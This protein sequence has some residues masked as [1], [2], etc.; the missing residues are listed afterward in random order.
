MKTLSRLLIFACAA[1][2]AFAQAIC[3]GASGTNNFVH[4][5]DPTA[6]GC[7]VV[8]TIAAN[9]TASVSIPDSSPYDGSEDT[10]VG[11]KNNSAST[12]ASVNLTGSDIFGFDGDG[13]CTFTFVGSSYCTTAQQNGT[14]PGDYQGPTST[15]T[16]TNA[17]TGSVN[18]APAIPANGGTAYFSLEGVPTVSL[19]VT[20]TTGTG[21]GSTSA[22]PVPGSLVLLGLGLACLVGW[23]LGSRVFA[24]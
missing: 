24:R 7:N 11:V 4:A 18:F 6:T 21:G 13:I 17:N 23:Q 10:L 19:A 12:I 5:P 14:D 9:G 1:T 2:A 8:I 15:F 3:P 16:V 22:T 20:V